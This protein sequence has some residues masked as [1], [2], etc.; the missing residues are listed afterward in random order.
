MT[1][2]PR[3]AEADP[4][5]TGGAADDRPAPPVVG[6]VGAPL[7]VRRRGGRRVVTD[8]V[9]GTDPAP[10]PEPERHSSGEN[11]ARLRADV[12]PHWG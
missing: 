6:A 4:A 7:V 2:A 10:S 8:P 11:D 5:T 12:P 1:V 9:P 3:D